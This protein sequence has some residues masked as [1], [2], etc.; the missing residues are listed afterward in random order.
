MERGIGL[1]GDFLVLEGR[2]LCAGL[3]RGE[4]RCRRSSSLIE[5]LVYKSQSSLYKLV[6]ATYVDLPRF[7]RCVISGT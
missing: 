3:R 2:G 7:R 6:E 5:R 1:L 4:R